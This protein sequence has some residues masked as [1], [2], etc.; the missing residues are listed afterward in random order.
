M[1]TFRVGIS[2]GFLRADGRWN[3]PGFDP[4]CLAEDD[5]FDVVQLSGGPALDGSALRGV[6]GLVLAGDVLSAA[7]LRDCAD[8]LAVVARAGVGYDKVDVAACTASGVALT[9]TPEAVRRPVAVAAL[10]LVLA[11]AGR[12]LVKDR[13]VRLGPP[14]FARRSDFMGV[15]LEGRTLASIGL[16]NIGAEMF[17]LALPFGMRHIACDPFANAEVAHETRVQLV[18]LETLFREADFLCVHCPL[19]EATRGLVN[20]DRLAAMKPTAFLINTA[21]GAIVDQPALE[22][23]LS[24]GAIAGAGLDVLDPE[25]PPAHAPILTFDNVILAPHALSWTD[26]AF[27]AIGDACLAS[28]RTVASGGVPAHVVNADVLATAV[29]TAKLDRFRGPHG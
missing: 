24:S 5:R 23:A 7:A 18:D 2:P 9:I 22:R 19:T 12:M 21:R 20:A 4:T 25:P 6:D 17:R 15:G 11:L 10:T 3:F 16:G 29:F 14:G 27:A 13:L 28:M 8:R 26:Q 1:S